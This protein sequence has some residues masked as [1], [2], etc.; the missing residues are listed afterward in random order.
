[1]WKIRSN[2]NPEKKSAY[3]DK[4]MHESLIIYTET[5]VKC[6]YILN[7][8]C[9]FAK[10]V[11]WD[12]AVILKR[13]IRLEEGLVG[14]I[15]AYSLWVYMYCAG[16]RQNDRN[17]IRSYRR[18]TAVLLTL[19]FCVHTRCLP[20]RLSVPKTLPRTKGCVTLSR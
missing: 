13:R 20:L 2:Y 3:C 9:W 8:F 16:N 11:V 15:G 19:M 10:T 4:I 1:M 5:T 6:F 17:D 18:V 7:C 12:V 14:Y